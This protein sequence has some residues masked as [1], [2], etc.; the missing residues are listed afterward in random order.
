MEARERH[1]VFDSLHLRLSSI[2]ASNLYT[3]IKVLR[4]DYD[5]MNR[6]S[7]GLGRVQLESAHV[8]VTGGSGRLQ[9]L[10]ITTIVSNGCMCRLCREGLQAPGLSSL[11][12]STQHDVDGLVAFRFRV[13]PYIERQHTRRPDQF[14]FHKPKR[15]HSIPFAPTS[16]SAPHH[17]VYLV[18]RGPSATI[19]ML[20]YGLPLLISLIEAMSRF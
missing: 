4:H 19:P 18:G 20:S 13:L 10:G 7:S 11:G 3:I 5:I 9:D 12:C 17:Q 15:T 14:P 1:R 6:V 16:S 8:S 2:Q